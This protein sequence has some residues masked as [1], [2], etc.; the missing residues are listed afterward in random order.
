MS[1]PSSLADISPGYP[2]PYPLSGVRSAL[3][4]FAAGWYGKNDAY[5]IAMADVPEVTCIDIDEEKMSIMEDIYPIDWNFIVGDVF[6]YEFD[7]EWDIITADCPLALLSVIWEARHS[8]AQYAH[9]ALIL[10]LAHFGKAQMIT[11]TP[12][13]NSV[14]WAVIED[15]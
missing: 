12:R 14:A 9:K 3:V 15:A 1:I 4:L 7:R 10:N 11:I 5:W 6:Q 2:F 8:L 13:S